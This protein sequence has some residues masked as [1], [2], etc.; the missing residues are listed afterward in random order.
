[1]SCKYLCSLESILFSKYFCVLC[2]GCPAGTWG[3]Q[4]LHTCVVTCPT[5]NF[6]ANVTVPLC[7]TVCPS[8][9][10][11]YMV[12]RKCYIGG[13][14]PTTPVRHYSDDLTGRCLSAC[15]S[16]YFADSNSGRCS[17][18]CL[19]NG[20]YADPTTGLC[21]QNCPSGYFRSNI[22]KSCLQTCTQG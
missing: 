11:A 8:N 18:F 19:T 21:V 20:Y 12:D 7:V 10:Y 4:E 16:G 22:T 9:Y 15:A 14:C 1:M 3:N 2:L 17:I 6:Y 5:D 13:S